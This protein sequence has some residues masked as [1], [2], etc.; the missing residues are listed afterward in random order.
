MSLA[1]LFTDVEGSTRLWAADRDAMS[2]SLLVH[3]AR[4]RAAIAEN[5][6]YVF[7]TAGGGAP[8]PAR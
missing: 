3:D 2:A 7:T 5:G 1:V 8:P 6:G 4:L